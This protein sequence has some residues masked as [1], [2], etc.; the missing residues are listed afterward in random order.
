MPDEE[1]KSKKIDWS[2]IILFLPFVVSAIFAFIS[3]SILYSP[4]HACGA[5]AGIM[6][7]VGEQMWFERF[8]AI[9]SE[10]KIKMSMPAARGPE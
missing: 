5:A 6:F 10:A 1:S 7:L 4:A 3:V 8:L 9:W 2:E